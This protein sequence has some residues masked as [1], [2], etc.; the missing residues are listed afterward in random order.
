MDWQNYL[1]DEIKRRLEDM[2]TALR[3]ALDGTA[4]PQERTAALKLV[5]EE[6]LSGAERAAIAGRR[7]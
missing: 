4:T 1:P 2:N 5:R 7:G 6:Q 3:I